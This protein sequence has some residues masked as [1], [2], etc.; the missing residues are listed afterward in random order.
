MHRGVWC[1]APNPGHVGYSVRLATNRNCYQ[2]DRL[3]TRLATNQIG[4][5][6]IELANNQKGPDRRRD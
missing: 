3:P 5:L 4:S 1:L 6:T 2:S